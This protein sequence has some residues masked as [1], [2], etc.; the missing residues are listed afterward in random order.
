MPDNDYE[1]WNALRQPYWPALYFLDGDGIVRDLRFGEGRYEE[2]E[3]SIQQLLGVERDLV[4]VE[5]L[6]VEAEA[7]WQ[8]PPDA[9]DL[10]GYGRGERLASLHGTTPS[11]SRTT[12]RSRIVCTPTG[13]R[14][15]GNRRSRRRR[16]Y[17]RRPTAPSPS[18]STTRRAPGALVGDLG[19]IPFQVLL[20]GE[21]P[22]PSH[23]EDVDEAGN[24]VLAEGRLYQLVRQSDRV[25]ER[26]LE[27]TFHGRGRRGLRLHLWMILRWMIPRVIGQAVGS[28]VGSGSTPMARRLSGDQPASS[29]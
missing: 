14:S 4:S 28:G 3:R 26:T 16:W 21:A 2:S 29:P 20:D 17:S 6:G 12:T 1:I 10:S 18:A 24:G 25:L 8:R 19:P 11:T 15:A 22:G 27:I 13:G 9:R 7:D 5:G 23:G